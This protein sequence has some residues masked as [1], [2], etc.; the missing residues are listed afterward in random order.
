[1]D[2]RTWAA[3][4]RVPVV[5]PGHETVFFP[6]GTT[7]KSKAIT[8]LQAAAEIEHQFVVQYL[9]AHYCGAKQWGAKIFKVIA[10]EE[11]GHLLT[12]QNLLRLLGESSHLARLETLT[13]DLAPTPFKLQPFSLPFVAC[14]LVA[15]SPDAQS[16]PPGLP[17]HLPP[18]IDLQEIHRVG[19]IYALLADLFTAAAA[20]SD[21]LDH[22][23]D[24]DFVDPA[25]LVGALN[26]FSDWRGATDLSNP[27]GNI[28]VLPATDQFASSAAVRESALS[29]IHLVAGQGEG[30]I[31][32]PVD[33][34][35]KSHAMRLQ[36]VYT[37]LLATPFVGPA[38]PTNPHLTPSDAHD[39]NVITGAAA[40]QAALALNRSY[41]VLLLNIALATMSGKNKDRI[42]CIGNAISAMFD[43]EKYSLKLISLPLRDDGVGTRLAAPPF[44]LP[45]TGIPTD[46]ATINARLQ[47]LEAIA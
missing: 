11:M 28:L 2:D 32:V 6:P 35:E 31:D 18:G 23:T 14:F 30:L 10:E 7:A 45:A 1:M 20:G 25:Q 41:E 34:N 21:P 15:E 44:T 8:L 46:I 47:E 26:L 27:N 29:A 39:E 9:Y 37:A 5:E 42:A 12:V 33:A 22:L 13:P 19:V 24:A 16:L 40:I 43:I 4:P 38:Y 17:E 36:E 3:S